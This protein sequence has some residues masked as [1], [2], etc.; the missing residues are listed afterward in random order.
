M[1]ELEH[2]FKGQMR[3]E[4]I[5]GWEHDARW[6]PIRKWR[7]DFV[8]RW[9]DPPI[10]IEIEGGV[11]NSGRHVRGTGYEGDC[12]KYNEATLRGWKVYRFTSGMVKGSRREAMDTLKRALAQG[13]DK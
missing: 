3:L 2:H 13:R 4:G 11:Y 9:V 5:T 10:L 12:R 1:S 6:H 7:S 8:F